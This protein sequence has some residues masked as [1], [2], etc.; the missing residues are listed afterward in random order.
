MNWL[1]VEEAQNWLDKPSEE[2]N[3]TERSRGAGYSFMHTL[4]IIG[5]DCVAVKGILPCVGCVG[6]VRPS[7]RDLVEVSIALWLSSLA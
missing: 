1:G 7:K 4:K 6:I 2:R 3:L 5:R